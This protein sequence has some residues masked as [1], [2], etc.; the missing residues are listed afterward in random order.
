MKFPV[1]VLPLAVLLFILPFPHTT[2]LRLLALAVGLV[3]SAWSWRREGFP[4]IPAKNAI[5][6]WSCCALLSLA[7]AVDPAYSLGEIKNEIGYAMAAFLSFV[8]LT[9]TRQ[10]AVFF[11]IALIL[12]N[13]VLTVLGLWDT[14]SSGTTT[15]VNGRAGGSGTYSTYQLALLPVLLWA[16]TLLRHKQ[17][18]N[19]IFGLIVLQLVVAAF[20]EQ[21][22]FWMVFAVQALTALYLL[23]ARGF[24]AISASRVRT[25]GIA[26]VL[27]SVLAV[28]GAEVKRQTIGWEQDPRLET[29]TGVATRIIDHP[30][31]GNGFGREVMKKAYPELLSQEYPAVWHAHNLFLNYGLSMGIPGMIAILALFLLLLR[32][33]WLLSRTDDRIVAMA[34]IC[35]V[36]LVT[37]VV[38]R[39]LTNDF[40]Q[41][42]LA[43]LFWA[44]AGMFFGY[45]QHAHKASEPIA[46]R[47]AEN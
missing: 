7:T 14:F 24:I 19:L 8:T 27:L 34:G 11:I 37:G 29:W 46:S 17:R 45:A 23:R 33:F 30:L 40:F 3:A 32:K 10:D 6:L 13:L 18:W 21:R 38:A 47:S 35:G 12:G 16:G 31:A 15:W 42:D 44:I 1:R 43:L 26:A 41:R 9:R 22:V 4:Q 25:I 2:A 39:N 28:T 36:L 5:L 20:V